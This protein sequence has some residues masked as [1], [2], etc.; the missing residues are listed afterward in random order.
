MCQYVP[1]R[2]DRCTEAA[3]QLY[4]SQIENS[5][6]VIPLQWNSEAIDFITSGLTSSLISAASGHIPPK[7]SNKV[8]RIGT[9]TLEKLRRRQKMPIGLGVMV[10]K[11]RNASN[12]LRIKYK[13]FKK[14]FRREL[15]RY[16]RSETD[17]F[18]N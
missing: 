6:P 3:I 18:Y 13:E 7:L 14:I 1:P 4:S 9:Q 2:W 11:P 5:L 17:M 10:S 15:R 12:H 16:I 8:V